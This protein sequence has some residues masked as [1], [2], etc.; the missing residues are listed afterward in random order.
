M[1][2]FSEPSRTKR[3]TPNPISLYLERL[4]E[5]LLLSG[6]SAPQTEPWDQGADDA[7]LSIPPT[8]GSL[9]ASP[10]PVQR[11]GAVTLTATD[12]NDPDG[13]VTVVQFYRDA[14]GNETL[15]TATDAYLGVDS[16]AGGGWKWIG[17]T[18]D[19]PV[20]TQTVFARAEDNE[21]D[22]GVA[23][24]TVT[25][26]NF[27]PQVASL[28]DGPDPITRPAPLTLTAYGTHDVD[29]TVTAV[30]FYR[31]ANANGT[32]ETEEDAFVG[33]GVQN[34]EDWS[35]TGS[36]AGLPTGTRAYFA[37]ARDNDG[38]WG[39]AASTLGTLYNTAPTIGSLSDDPDPVERPSVLTLTAEAV[40]DLDGT[41][42]LVQFFR[43]ENG[44]GALDPGTDLLLGEDTDGAD[45]WSWS[46]PTTGWDQTSYTYFARA[47]DNDDA[48]SNTV[49]TTGAVHGA[50]PRIDDLTAVPNPVTRPAV[51]TLTAEDVLDA[52]GTV[53][54]VEFY[55]DAN[56][57]GTLEP[58]T[59]TLL[60][61]GNQDDDDWS[62]AGSTAGWPAGTFAFFARGQDDLGG[63]GP[64]ASVLVTMQNVLPVIG[65]LADTPDPVT[66]PDALTITAGGVTDADGTI[67]LVEFYRD[68][69]GNGTFEPGSDVLLGSDSDGGGGRKWT[70][71]TLGWSV[72]SQRYFARA[73]DNEGGW[74]AV[75]SVTGTV[76]NAPPTAGA[77]ADAPDPVT[78][79]DDLTLTLTGTSDIDGA[80]VL[81]EFYRDS[82]GSGTLDPATDALLGTDADGGD[83]WSWT[84]S[85]LGWP[86][87]AQ[88][89]FAR[90]QDNNGGWSVAASVT[91]QVQNAPPEIASLSQSP[92]P[93]GIGGVLTLTAAGVQDPDGTV[94][95]VEF[96][97]E[98][99]GVAG[100][101]PASDEFLGVGTAAGGGT[102][103]LDVDTAG[104][105]LGD[106]SYMARAQ[107]GDGAWSAVASTTGQV[108]Y[109]LVD[110]RQVDGA[111]ITFYDVDA[112]N[113]II[114]PN[115][116]AWTAAQF[117]PATK[118]IFVNA[119]RIGDGVIDLI[120]LLGNGSKTADL[121]VMI[122]G[123]TK[124]GSLVDARTNARDLG[125][126]VSDGPVGSVSL[127]AGI[128]GAHLADYGEPDELL[129]VYSGGALQSLVAK[130][131]VGGDVIV[132][133]NLGLLQILG[134][135]L[136]GD[137]TLTGSKL[138]TVMAIAIAGQGGNIAGDIVAEDG[139]S[140]V[141]AIGGGIS[142][143]IQA[144]AGG[145][146]T[147]IATDGP[148][149]SPVIHGR[150]GV[151]LVQAI[152][153]GVLSS[154]TSGAGIGS[155]MAIGGDIDLRSGRS[156]T[157]DSTVNAIMAI[158]GSILGDG[159]ASPDIYVDDG[160]LR[161][162]M[163]IG[164]RI[165]NL[166]VQVNGGS[167]G[168]GGIGALQA[169]G[170]G[171]TGLSLASLGLSSLYCPSNL[172]A[173]MTVRGAVGSLSVGGQMLGTHIEVTGGS[174]GSVYAGRGIES[175]SILLRDASGRLGGNLASVYSGGDVRNTIVRAGT[176]GAV[177]AAGR[178][179]EDASD[180]EDEIQA[181]DRQFIVIDAH[182]FAVV[183]PSQ[184]HVVGGVRAWI[185][186][187]R[188]GPT[189][190]AWD[191]V[192]DTGSPDDRHTRDDTLEL[193][194]TFSEVIYGSDA[195]VSV[196]DPG[197]LAVAPGAVSGWR[198]NMLTI[199]LS[200]PLTVEGGYEVG[201]SG[202]GT[203][204]DASGNPLEG[205]ADYVAHF[206][207]DKTAPTLTGWGIDED[208]GNPGDGVTSE[209]T[210]ELTFT[211]SEPVFGDIA[212]CTLQLPDSHVTP[213]DSLTGW[214]T[215]TLVMTFSKALTLEGQYVVTFRSVNAVHDAAGN[216]LNDGVNEV[217]CFALDSTAPTLA[218]WTLSEDGGE[219]GDGVT[220]DDTPELTFTF[221][222]AIYGAATDVTVLD[223]EGYLVAP[224]SITGWGTDTLI[225][226]FTT[227]LDAEGQYTLTL[228]GTGTIED[229]AG[230]PLNGG[231]SEVEHFTLD[232]TP[233]AVQAWNVVEDTGDPDDGLTGDT[234][235]ELT[236]AFN[237]AV[238]GQD[239]DVLV[240][241]PNADPIA[242]DAIAGW[243]SSTL[244]LTFS[245]PLALPG[246]YEVR[247][248]GTGTIR[249][250]AGNPLNG[251]A[252]HVV[253]FTIE[254]EAPYVQSWGLADD[255][256]DAGDGVTSDSTPVLTFTF[257][258]TVYGQDAD[259]AV[260]DPDL[261]PLMPDSIASWGT[262]ALTVAFTTPLA[263][264][265][266]YRLTLNG[267]GT[268]EDAAGNPLNGGADYLA[269]FTFDAS[270][271]T[272]L[273]WD[274]TE[275]TGNPGDGETSDSTPVLTFTFD[276]PVYGSDA[277]VTV[278]APDLSP[279]TPGTISGW[280]TDTLI[281]TLSTPLTVEGQYE[282][283]LN[284]AG[285]IRDLAG[286][287]L[288]GGAD[289]V[290]QFRFDQ[291]PPT[292]TDWTLEDDTGDPGD[293]VTGDRTPLLTFTFSED[294]LGQD[295]DV[296]VVNPDSQPVTP[297]SIAGWG[298]DTLA[299]AFTTPLMVDGQYTV[300]LNGT[301]T[302][303]DAAGN[304]LNGGDDVVVHFTLEAVGP[305][306]LS[307][308]LSEDTGQPG[309]EITSDSTPQLTFSFSKPAFGQD[310]DVSVLDPT[311]SPVTPNAISG[312]GS[313][314]L[315]VTFTTPL[316]LE[317]QYTVTLKGT[318]TIQDALGNP[319][320]GG[321]DEEAHFTLDRSGPSPTAWTVTDDTG[322]PGDG[323]TR[324]QTPVI[325]FDFAED[326]FGQNTDVT[327]LNP[328]SFPIVPNAISGWGTDTLTLTF[329]SPLAV[330]GEYE[331]RLNGTGTIEDAA[332]NP[333]NDG[334]DEV[335]HFRL[336][337][338]APT[339]TDW[340]LSEDTGNP[341]DAITSDDTP[342]LTFGFTE[343]VQGMADYV[344]VL[345][346]G[347]YLGWPD[348]AT[349]WGSDTLLVIFSTALTL[350]GQYIV[351]LEATS[352]I[353]DLAG[354]PLNGGT[355]VNVQF[356][357]DTGAPTLE[358][359][360]VD[361]D[362]GDPNDHAT[363][364][365]TPELTFEFSEVIYGQSF[366]VTVLRPGGSPIS[367]DA[368]AGW[369]TDTLVITFSTPLPDE[370]PYTVI[371]KGTST[372]V[373]RAGNPLNGGL[374]EV[375]YFTFDSS[376]AYGTEFFWFEGENPTSDTFNNHSWY[377]GQ[378]IDFDLFSPGV[379]EVSDGYWLGHYT[380]SPSTAEANYTFTVT[381]GGSYG[382]WARLSAYRT[383]YEYSVDGGPRHEIV[384]D[385][386][387]EYMTVTKAYAGARYIAWYEVGTVELSPGSHTVTVHVVQ[388]PDV[389]GTQG[390][391]D[392]MCLTNFPW[393]P[394]GTL[395]PDQGPTPGPD[396]WYPFRYGEDTFS[397]SSIIDMSYLLDDVAGEHGWVT[398][399]GDSLEF[400]D[401]TPVKFWGVCTGPA[402][403]QTTDEWMGRQADYYAKHG[404][405]LVRLHPVEWLLGV[406]LKD[407]GTGERYIDPDSLDIL[408]RWF[409]ILK[410]RGIYMNWIVFYPH[411]ITPDDGY[412][413][414]L[415]NE[416]RDNTR[417]GLE[418][419]DTSGM[420]NF[421]PEL[422]DASWE[423]L[424]T[425]LSHVN[426]YT[427]LAYKDDAAL[428][429]LEVQNEDCLFWHWPLEYL[430][431][432]NGDYPLHSAILRELWRQWVQDRYGNDTALTAAWE[433]GMHST[434]SVTNSDMDIY[435]P[436]EFLYDGPNWN[437]EEEKTRMGDFIHFLADTQRAFYEQRQQRLDGLGW[438][439]ATIST[440][441]EAGGICADA[442][443]L[444]ADDGMDIIDRHAYFGSADSD[445]YVHVGPIDNRSHLY[446]PGRYIMAGDSHVAGG[447]YVVLYQVEDKPAFQTEWNLNQPS[448]WRAEAAP[449][450]AFYGMGLQGWD[451]SLHFASRYAF[452]EN[453]WPGGHGH[454][455]SKYVNDT[456]LYMGQFPALSFAIYNGHIQ[457]ADLAAARRLNTEDIFLGFD[458][459]SQ[460][461]PGG[462][463][464]GEDDIYVPPEVGAIGRLTFKADDD[465]QVS[466]SERVDYNDYWN[467]G[468]QVIE[469][470]TGE[471]TW[472]YG[473]GVVTLHGDK[474][475]A[476]VGFAGGHHFDLPGVSVD[477]S[478]EFVSLIF[479]PLDD[480]PLVDSEHILVTAMAKDK[481]TNAQFSTD[482]SQLE[483]LG[484]SP[485]M[486][487]PVQ[488]TIT[489][490]GD[491][492]TSA[493]VVDV[494]GVP[495]RTDVERS[496]NTITID[497]RYQTYYYE[498]QRD[499]SGGRLAGGEVLT[500][501][502]QSTVPDRP[503]PLWHG[504]DDLPG[505]AD[506]TI[507]SGASYKWA[508]PSRTGRGLLE[509]LTADGQ[510][511]GVLDLDDLTGGLGL[512]RGALS[513]VAVSHGAP[514]DPS[515]T[516]PGWL[517]P[518][519]LKID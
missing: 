65:S 173:E 36:T 269:H 177:I 423:Y 34:V 425:L 160:N 359:W 406:L 330:E 72:G 505:L 435:S 432:R 353:T 278:L 326:I 91:G 469:S 51:L 223:P 218:G 56:G 460:D 19:W 513:N 58:A 420:I 288:N 456:P 396:V 184:E 313:S 85:T 209:D 24:T 101:D 384:L 115:V 252:E 61:Q 479:T 373:D 245:T 303:E 215:D 362:T 83:G 96:Y 316:A 497:G 48:W 104:M 37:R 340:Y 364:D 179:T 171:I 424:E 344:S 309:D 399:V 64:V 234:T 170:A 15:E 378:G 131:D 90:V 476:I 60:G 474:T 210:P 266:Q 108:S 156:I 286:N 296:S 152:K 486:L 282:V 387:H 94:A 100:L 307:W 470:M 132:G 360:S 112:S 290:V 80:V 489:F 487:E 483:V 111:T 23:S 457:E 292:V 201:L 35:W 202:T 491:A 390:A 322:V 124:L 461:L 368:I 337:R 511:G 204:R 86:T 41:V 71:A 443:N 93:V 507:S 222:E 444:W 377:E 220:G 293:Y 349:G 280:G 84:G 106:Y 22:S 451:G 321:I 92:E 314:T 228:K 504:P 194:F 271:P 32:L 155:I 439:G 289:E 239:A 494:F 343:D 59:D 421:M 385:P 27:L 356:T 211:F 338:T 7:P 345:D 82:D 75:I 250:L 154:I 506:A 265:G 473:Q 492:I 466:D 324:D 130:G 375:V 2:P 203:I 87:G 121:G 165:E 261:G 285:T 295:A 11:P 327:V 189:V 512:W 370:G 44:N 78:R 5:R 134:G 126:V 405:N 516:W 226:A 149:T 1:F 200:T 347:Y 306:V 422:Q 393:W 255:T 142:G 187:D 298:T 212:D 409:A 495:T 207:L 401:G 144:W 315:V 119:G 33:N 478:T 175:S 452:M 281:V 161:T 441:W 260:L 139:V 117:N 426:P 341:D 214:G 3:R 270:G 518:D 180:G 448:P 138:G 143:S 348:A 153:G 243:G 468:A 428:A 248:S 185:G 383:A 145:V 181:T 199:L 77:L 73:L 17:S 310:S 188:T 350:D 412:P 450:F 361:E 20:G 135:D 110:S 352:A 464:P 358:D 477:V 367:P 193:T 66:R 244:I 416:L 102:W 455:P 386:A 125:F 262:N 224:D 294:V 305:T 150:N 431:D 394:A 10:D 62:W 371:L 508:S 397:S 454:G 365:D 496:G 137:V 47:Q 79:P 446:E 256:G 355:D 427:G 237:E 230:N 410:D 88:T 498:V 217:V 120:L 46:G 229:G 467:Q 503:R 158:N 240:L 437:K 31:D 272:V 404:L 163:A 178:I 146:G 99:D 251:G 275:D 273:D 488:A 168:A 167:S 391:I 510:S 128:I 186:L 141:M 311:S 107:D 414:D 55:R 231:V 122:Q 206:T 323:I 339:V 259:V 127:Q 140:A 205:G 485:L 16:S 274:V 169:T 284:G 514:G 449:L 40:H 151:N 238:Y 445:Y 267:T 74:S 515:S 308:G 113:G 442:A 299:L 459:L 380:N 45:G 232:K 509:E 221:S 395:Q 52:D 98:S 39:P 351:T 402:S 279:V 157:A 332:G 388:H 484:G 103:E 302:I 493:R 268:I 12:V 472:D 233:P 291:T 433:D 53:V 381:E 500:A 398:R 372:I 331:V 357:L 318:G 208:T 216:P 114:N 502:G 57:N 400:E 382:W 253:H 95:L 38:D 519:W 463:W 328:N 197:S 6:G 242:P 429:V 277:D 14:N 403:I 263:V 118:A 246:Q 116:I 317:G 68:G 148:I 517:G 475:Q 81:A 419:K 147:V 379:P 164:G 166:S 413:T 333:L 4:E 257:S 63:W 43:D 254:S 50:L 319:L 49:S 249:D 133:G 325:V 415:Y 447:Q 25:V 490:G 30:E 76:L 354:N 480:E 67:A 499:R 241:D 29:G 458:A 195:D 430:D 481:Q 159:G 227:P 465:L 392:C 264:E 129:S 70:G 109:A 136:N 18:M 417:G 190:L 219:P 105:E 336:D 198:T 335:V 13:V 172:E 236:F 389:A 329:T 283:R 8:I 334:A 182:S 9:S 247:L 28:V 363:G 97:R 183:T 462:G 369:G 366:D 436:W 342:R 440:N 54:A 453:G 26:L 123:N 69:N 411:V 297:D 196:L 320:N 376:L 408:D 482:Y 312:W 225:V 162:L 21:G 192:E 300:T 287:P 346:P 418:G 276:E 174:V 258:E 89:Y 176:L 213:P 235:P 471:L 434:D 304:P 501:A 374:D 438:G 191:L 301:G 42:A 407:A